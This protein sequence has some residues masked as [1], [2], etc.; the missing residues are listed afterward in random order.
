MNERHCR[1][2]ELERQLRARGIDPTDHDDA[3]VEAILEA[4]HNWLGDE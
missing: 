4:K 1:L 3:D 2:V